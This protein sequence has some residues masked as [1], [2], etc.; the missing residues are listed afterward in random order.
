MISFLHLLRCDVRVLITTFYTKGY[1]FTLS[2]CLPH[3]QCTPS[4]STM[5]LFHQSLRLVPILPHLWCD[6]SKLTSWYFS[7]PP[8]GWMSVQAYHHHL[9]HH[10]GALLAHS[11]LAQPLPPLPVWCLLLHQTPKVI[12]PSPLSFLYVRTSSNPGIPLFLL[13]PGRHQFSMWWECSIYM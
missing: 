6:T 5:V 2:I 9:Y 12:V 11:R 13:L 7:L 8:S 4:C 1:N 10:Q 3:N